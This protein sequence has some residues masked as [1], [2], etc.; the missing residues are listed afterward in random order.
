MIVEG[1]RDNM[2]RFRNDF[3]FLYKADPWSV[4]TSHDERPNFQVNN[5]VPQ[6]NLE[7]FLIMEH[8]TKEVELGGFKPVLVRRSFVVNLDHLQNNL[9]L[10]ALGLSPKYHQG[11]L[12]PLLIVLFVCGL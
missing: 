5:N 9:F 3:V 11:E 2:K 4:K 8:A 1:L 10:S 7:E 6:C 12:K